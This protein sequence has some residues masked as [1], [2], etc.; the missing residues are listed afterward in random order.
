MSA[1]TVGHPSP[2]T[3]WDDLVRLWEETDGP[4]GCK[5]EIIEGIVTVSPTP[6]ERSQRHR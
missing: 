2:A 4:E 1:L 5:V 6:S 3:S